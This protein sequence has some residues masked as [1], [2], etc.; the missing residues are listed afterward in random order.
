M[1]S[2]LKTETIQAGLRTRFI[3]QTIHYWPSVGS[4]NDELKRLAE[5]GAPEGALA[6]TDE[7]LAGRGRLERRWMAPFGSSLL[8]SLLFRPTFLASTQAQQLTMVC[9][10][11]VADAVAN[12]TGLQPALKWPNDLLLEGKKLGGV[13]TELGFSHTVDTGQGQD[14]E[15]TRLSW[16]I[17]GVGLNVNADF[18]S[19]TARRD[20]PALAD[21]AISLAMVL[22]RPVSRLS[23]LQSYLTGVETRYEAMRAA[24]SPY[25]EWVERLATLGQQVAV[26]TPDGVYQGVA[27]EVDETGAL[28]LRQ[29]G[30][31]VVRIFTGDVTL[32]A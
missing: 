14:Y 3:A 24:D 1:A 20:W 2:E 31:Q 10:L 29:L 12:V 13:L 9:S 6:I 26:T 30:G 5:G 8:M 21:T 22:G 16:V 32:R 23:L 15:T 7:Q 27:E 17:V 11:A 18:T 19:P 25:Q 28:L 4:T